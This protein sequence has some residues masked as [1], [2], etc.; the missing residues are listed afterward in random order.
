AHVF[1]RLIQAHSYYSGA[2]VGFFRGNILGLIEDIALLK[3][4]IFPSV[5]RLL[6]RI[7]DKI[8]AAVNQLPPLKRKLFELGYAAK[9]EYL[10]SEGATIHPF[11]D[12]L[13]FSK[14][15]AVLGGRLRW[16]L[17]GAA[18]ISPQTVEFLRIVFCCRVMEG[19]GQTEGTGIGTTTLLHDV[20]VGHVGPPNPAC[21]V[22]L[23]DVADMDYLVSDRPN[24]R[25]ELCVR[26]PSVIRG[27]YLMPDKTA[28]TIDEEGWLHSGDV[29]E[30]L[31]NGCFR[32]IDRKK[33]LFKLAQGE[34]VAPEKI[35][36]IIARSPYIA[37]CFVYGDSLQPHLVAIVV[38]DEEV[39]RIWAHS[40]A[41]AHHS[42]SELCQLPELHEMLFSDMLYRCK[43]A[44][45]G[46][47]EIPKAIFVSAEVFSIENDILTP[48]LKMKRNVAQKVYAQQIKHLYEQ[49][50]GQIKA[51]L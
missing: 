6:N 10:Y 35:E 2:S 24:P 20:A 14:M 5:P 26:G 40:N 13:V 33:N 49:T 4:T 42:F 34:Y 21:E 51:S 32:I 11:W 47:F 45:L 44:A 28:E 38:P 23:V 37:Q 16:I 19:Y 36:N 7:Y 8:T 46:G 50:T 27:Y 17:T 31:P 3:P 22:K 41:L 30:L 39:V 29:A 1:E 48:T 15:A 43:E 9:R 18:P 12:K 25:G